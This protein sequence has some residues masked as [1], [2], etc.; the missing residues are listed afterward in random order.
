MESM[1]ELSVLSLQ[2]FWKS[3]MISKVFCFLKLLF[4]NVCCSQQHAEGIQRSNLEYH[5]GDK[6]TQITLLQ[7]GVQLRKGNL[8]ESSRYSQ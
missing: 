3:K 1:W 8:W 2:C 5:G 4:V 6:C 7:I